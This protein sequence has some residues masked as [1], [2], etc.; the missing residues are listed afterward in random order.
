MDGED[1]FVIGPH[2]TSRIKPRSACLL[3]SEVYDDVVL[4]ITSVETED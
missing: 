3:E 2:D 1:P 4:H